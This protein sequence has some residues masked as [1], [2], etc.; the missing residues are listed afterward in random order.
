MGKQDIETV[1]VHGGQ[2]PDSVTGAVMPPIVL[3]TTFAQ[4]GPGRHQGF[5]VCA[6]GGIPPVRRWR[7]ALPLS[8][9]VGAGLPSV[10]AA[11]R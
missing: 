9:T 2:A 7:H 10:L 8:K 6:D 5:E 1:A 11:P 4:D 3:S